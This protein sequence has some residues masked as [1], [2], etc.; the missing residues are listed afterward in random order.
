MF[1]REELLG[2]T[3][4][5]CNSFDLNYAEGVAFSSAMPALQAELI[6]AGLD[7]FAV[8]ASQ[9]RSA[10]IDGLDVTVTPVVDGDP[11]MF[12]VFGAFESGVATDARIT[13]YDDRSVEIVDYDVP[14]A[15]LVAA[16]QGV[17]AAAGSPFLRIEGSDV[18][19]G[20][21]VADL[22]GLVAQAVALASTSEQFTNIELNTDA[23]ILAL[24]SPVATD[25]DVPA[26]VADLRASQ[27]WVGKQFIVTYLQTQLTIVD[28]VA[29]VGDD[30]TDGH[31]VEEFAATW[32]AGT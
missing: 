16:V 6:A 7:E 9:Q 10:V 2:A 14:V 23:G 24:S 21:V 18:A 12:S 4:D 5:P 8:T 1:T 25:P 30:Y 15:D 17:L 27:V 28:G 20:G 31:V 13:L 29:T 19:V 32:N 26:A 3:L 22:S 11:A